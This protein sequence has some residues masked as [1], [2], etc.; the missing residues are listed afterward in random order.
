MHTILQSATLHVL[1]PC[2]LYICIFCPCSY[3]F[4]FN[5]AANCNKTHV[6]LGFVY[7]SDSKQIDRTVH[8]SCNLKEMTKTRLNQKTNTQRRKLYSY[9]CKMLKYLFDHFCIIVGY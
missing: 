5:V 4:C 2:L 7:V 9:Y 6:C 3:S 8:V 1:W